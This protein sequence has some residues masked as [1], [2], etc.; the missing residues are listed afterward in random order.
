M[1][2]RM[3]KTD[4]GLIRID[5]TFVTQARRRAQHEAWMW[6][7]HTATPRNGWR[8]HAAC[9]GTDVNKFYGQPGSSAKPAQSIL[10]MC[11]D[12]PVRID[13]GATLV[14]EETNNDQNAIHGIR[15][16]MA[17]K[18]RENLYIKMSALGFR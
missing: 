14:R 18:T 4:D 9:I 2:V 3:L 16:G 1:M 15:A 7:Y 12:C 13:C 5:R 6:R 10:D 8:Q 17:A 11:A